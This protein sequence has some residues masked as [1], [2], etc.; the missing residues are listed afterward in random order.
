M[1]IYYC[2][3]RVHDVT[4]NRIYTALSCDTLKRNLL[5][6]ESET[7]GET[8]TCKLS[9]MLRSCV[10]ACVRVVRGNIFQLERL[11]VVGAPFSENRTAPT[12]N[13]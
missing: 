10:R 9:V 6:R 4:E 3:F 8:D 7:M 5:L 12:A 13:Y 11:P 2:R 1:H